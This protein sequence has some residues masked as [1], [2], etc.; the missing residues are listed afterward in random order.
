MWAV[1]K[2]RAVWININFRYVEDELTLPVRQR[3]PRTPSFISAQ[4]SPRVDGVPRR[5]RRP[6]AHHHDRRRQRRAD[7]PLARSTTRTPSPVARPSATS[8][9]A[10]PTTTTSSTPA[11]RPAC[12]RAWCGATRTCSSP[13]AEALDLPTGQRVEL[14]PEEWSSVVWPTGPITMLPIAPLMHGAT[15]WG[16]MQG[17]FVGNKLVLVA[18][19]RPGRRVAARRPGEGQRRDDHRRR[20][21]PPAGRGARRARTRD[22]YDLS[23]LIA[24]VEHGGGLLAVGEG[25]VLR[26]PAR[27]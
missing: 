17:A 26:A 25:R 10:R 24:S 9:R 20:H 27:T 14:T 18:D 16:V 21:G 5:S 2:I 11:A 7:L 1:F 3:R 15:Q 6:E 23:S 19:V 22:S 4:Y 12:P 8:A 13:S